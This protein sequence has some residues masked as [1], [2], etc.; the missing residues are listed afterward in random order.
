LRYVDNGDIP[1]GSE[2]AYSIYRI[3]TVQ[4]RI[5]IIA[6]DSTLSVIIIEAWNSAALSE[7]RVY[8]AVSYA[9]RQIIIELTRAL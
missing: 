3:S 4:I 1:H 8:A 7:R 6:I 9:P 2:I 5:V